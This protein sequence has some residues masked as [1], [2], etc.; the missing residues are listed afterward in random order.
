VTQSLLMV[1]TKSRS[2]RSLETLPRSFIT[3]G[4][5]NGR[6]YKEF[7]RLHLK[8]GESEAE[9]VAVATLRQSS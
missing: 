6:E 9:E 1:R 2:F 4:E 7:E 3:G 5:R 8:A